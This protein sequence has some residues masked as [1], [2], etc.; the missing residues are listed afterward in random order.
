[1]RAVRRLVQDYYL[2]P[3]E[4]LKFTERFTRRDEHARVSV[5]RR[6]PGGLRQ[7]VYAVV[8]LEPRYLER[9]GQAGPHFE[10]ACHEHN[11]GMVNALNGARANRPEALDEANRE[12]PVRARDLA[13][14]WEQLKKDRDGEPEPLT[15]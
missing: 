8:L 14:R 15:R 13:S 12:T 11:Y 10:Y 2:G 1:M 4:T 3:G 6:R 7:A 5:H 9:P